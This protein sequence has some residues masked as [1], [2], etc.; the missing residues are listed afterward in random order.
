LAGGQPKPI[1]E[2]S[3]GHKDTEKLAGAKM[4]EIDV[5]ALMREFRAIENKTIGKII[6]I[7]IPVVAQCPNCHG[8]GEVDYVSCSGEK[9]CISCP[10]CDGKGEVNCDPENPETKFKVITDKITGVDL[11]SR[12]G[13][14]FA[15][16]DSNWGLVLENIYFDKEE[17][18]KACD[19][20]NY[21]AV[22]WKEL[23][24]EKYK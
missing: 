6:Y 22:H 13:L 19:R 24:K 1:D 12:S 7:I 2:N 20:K 11:V 5:S 4:N 17:A 18:Q 23:L 10:V 16:F 14:R 3:K 9:Y 21:E 15:H 8:S